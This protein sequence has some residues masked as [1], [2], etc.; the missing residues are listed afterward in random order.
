MIEACDNRRSLLRACSA[1]MTK[2]TG[3][4]VV[5]VE[6]C[7]KNQMTAIVP[8]TGMEWPFPEEEGNGEG[9]VNADMMDERFDQPFLVT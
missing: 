5:E 8:I 2:D 7:L 6:I 1:R 4:M 9:Q 3:I